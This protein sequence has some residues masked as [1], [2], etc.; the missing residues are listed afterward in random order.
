MPKAGYDAQVLAPEEYANA[1]ASMM[2]DIWREKM[3]EYEV[4]D[5]GDLWKSFN[6]DWVKWN[7]DTDKGRIIHTFLQYGIY[8]ERG[9][10][11]EI[12][13][14]NTGD[15]GQSPKRMPK[16]WL[17]KKYLYSVFRL[18]EHFAANYGN[19]FCKIIKDTLKN[20][21]G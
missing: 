4:W 3:Q 6:D 16:P 5:S 12:S 9:H 1:W 13:V 8:V 15:I 7:E 20:Q 2:V 18:G 21:A 11:R 14:G 17:S 19:Q 10:G